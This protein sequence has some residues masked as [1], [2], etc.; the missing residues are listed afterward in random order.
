[1]NKIYKIANED[2]NT[3]LE[4]DFETSK[5]PILLFLHGFGDSLNTIRP[6]IN[7]Q[8]KPFSIVAIDM[9]GCGKSSWNIRPITLEHYFEVAEEFVDIV[10][11][12]REVYVIGHSLGS[13]SALYLLRK[14]KAKYATLVGAAH[15][16]IHKQKL[17]FGKKYLIPISKE[18]A[19]ESYLKLTATPEA[20]RKEAEM[21]ANMIVNNKNLRFKKFHYLVDQQMLNIEY[22]YENYYDWYKATD[23]YQL[24]VG[25]FDQYTYPEEIQLVAKQMNKNFKIIK[26]AGHATF[27]DNSQEIYDFALKMF[28]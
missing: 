4:D 15:Y 18:N 27:Y 1:M 14:N 12:G 10:L 11:K 20:F 28:K 6:I 9:P 7:M 5:K 13:L 26:N 23:K 2:I 8:N 19:I 3:F 21:Y 22:I 25:E 17:E 16:L 24:C